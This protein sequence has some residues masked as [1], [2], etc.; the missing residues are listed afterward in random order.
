MVFPRDSSV[1]ESSCARQSERPEQ[2]EEV[3]NDAAG[4]LVR[5]YA[6]CFFSLTEKLHF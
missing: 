5:L 3:L 4:I 6:R 2:R 1:L